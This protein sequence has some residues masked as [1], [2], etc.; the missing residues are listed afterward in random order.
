MYAIAKD[1]S[2]KTRSGT[3]NVFDPNPDDI[4]IEDIAHALSFHVSRWLQAG[5]VFYPVAKHCVDMAEHCIYPDLCLE[6]LLHDASE[7]Y[8]MDIPKP[9]KQFLPEYQKLEDGLMTVIARK[10]GFNYPLS[11][12]VKQ[13]DRYFLEKE[14]NEYVMAECPPLLFKPR[15]YKEKFLKLFYEF[16]G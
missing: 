13:L 10:F 9:I 6:A 16:S 14:W 1:G 3:I 2:I 7:A 5:S 12:H 4:H 8:I 11:D 15:V